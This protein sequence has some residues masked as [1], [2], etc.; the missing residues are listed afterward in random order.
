MFNNFYTKLNCTHSFLHTVNSNNTASL[1]Q[2][3]YDNI[4]INTKNFTVSLTL[5]FLQRVPSIFLLF[6]NV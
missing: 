4:V 5:I 2:Q 3:P 1:V 6:S